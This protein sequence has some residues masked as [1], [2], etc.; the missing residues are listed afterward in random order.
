MTDPT[1]PTATWGRELNGADEVSA[2]GS[3]YGFGNGDALGGGVGLSSTGEGGGGVADGFCIGLGGLRLARTHGCSGCPGGG[4]D[5]FRQRKS[6]TWGTSSLGVGSIRYQ[7]E[8]LTGR[9]SPEVIQ[10]V[11]RQNDGRFRS[12]YQRGLQ[13]NPNLTGR[14]MV[15]FAIDRHGQVAVATDGGSDFPD[16]AVRRCVI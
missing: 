1:A 12:C 16:A 8:S 2:A 14:V 10:R 11:V 5:R 15:K 13:A 6:R 9:S 4:G 7:I 3:L